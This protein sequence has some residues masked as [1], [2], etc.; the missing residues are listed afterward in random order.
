[1]HHHGPTAPA[2]E[3]HDRSK[4]GRLPTIFLG[5]AAFGVIGSLIGLAMESS[6]AQ[7]AHSWLFACTFFFTLAC[8]GLFWTLI[9]HATD[10]EWS[11]LVRRRTSAA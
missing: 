7:F 11:V 1:M 8:G 4:F 3:T 5:A 10:A 6:R 9:H 2:V